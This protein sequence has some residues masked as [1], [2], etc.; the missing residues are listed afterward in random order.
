MVVIELASLM[1]GAWSCYRGVHFNR[2]R[3]VILQK[4]HFIRGRM[5][6]QRWFYGGRMVILQRC[7]L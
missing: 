6:I 1:E 3:M 4:H 7:S 2:R 5:V